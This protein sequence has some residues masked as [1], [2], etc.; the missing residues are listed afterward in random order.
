VERGRQRRHFLN[1]RQLETLATRTA[2]AH[3]ASQAELVE[4][5]L[6]KPLQAN[7]RLALQDR[8]GGGDEGDTLGHAADVGLIGLLINGGGKPYFSRHTP[9]TSRAMISPTTAPD[10]LTNAVK[11]SASRPGAKFCP[12]SKMT[13]SKT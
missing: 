7:G 6:V 5:D 1:P 10:M 11:A 2:L 4:L 3:S 12:N 9:V 13:A 8:R